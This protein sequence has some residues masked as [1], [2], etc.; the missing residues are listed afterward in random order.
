M[1]VKWFGGEPFMCFNEVIEPIS[2]YAKHLC[3]QKGIN[4]VNTATTNGYLITE[5]IAKK[6]EFLN[7]QFFQI[8]L[9]GDKEH[10]NLTRIAKNDSSFDAILRNINLICQYTKQANVMIR[11]NYDNKNLNPDKIFDQINDA[12]LPEYRKNI[13]LLFRKVWQVKEV[14]NAKEKIKLLIKKFEDVGFQFN[15]G[16]DLVLNSMPCYVSQKGMRVISPNG[17]IGKCSAKEDF[18]TEPLG[19]LLQDG[20]IKWTNNLPIPE[21]FSKPL[22]ENKMCLSCKHLP[23]CMGPC[24]RDLDPQSVD[25]Y[26]SRCKGR[27]NDLKFA[28][29]IVLWCESH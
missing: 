17:M 1:N 26:N 19:C 10:H 11:I 18:E 27:S 12:I 15:A 13:E 2:T 4:F 6:L 25:T 28:D 9:D 29:S 24:P 16:R 23:V 14:D 7:F 3:E 21:I 5:T 8:T 22:F 20:T